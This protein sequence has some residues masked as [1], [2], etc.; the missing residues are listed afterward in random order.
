MF[1][2]MD[3]PTHWVSELVSVDSPPPTRLI[4]HS[5]TSYRPFAIAPR[6][7]DGATDGNRT[8]TLC[9]EGRH[10]TVTSLPHILVEISPAPPTGQQFFYEQSPQSDPWSRHTE[11]NGPPS[12]AVP[13]VPPRPGARWGV[14][15]D[16]VI[17]GLSLQSRYPDIEGSY[18]VRSPATDTAD[19][20]NRHPRIFQY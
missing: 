1:W 20:P 3:V 15:Q 14:L 9:L 16:P 4:F 12:S 10:A 8:R 6:R 5:T 19:T 11:S 17:D 18:T 2:R 13:D 7:R